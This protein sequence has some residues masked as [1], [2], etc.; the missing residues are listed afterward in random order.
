[1]TQD[2]A[3]AAIPSPWYRSDV[4]A[5]DW[6]AYHAHCAPERVAAVDLASARRFTYATY[7]DRIGRL[8]TYLTKTASVGKGDRI[9][10]LAANSTD[11]LEV[12]FACARIGAIF[13]PINWRLAAPEINYILSDCAPK[14][15][16]FDAEMRALAEEACK[17][18]SIPHELVLDGG[19]AGSSYEVAVTETPF[20][21][22]VSPATQEDAWTILYTSGTTGRP[23]GAIITHA[24]AFWN[25]IHATIQVR[26]SRE[27]VFLAV[28]PLFHTGGL[29]VYTNPC[30]FFGGANIIMR[31][32]DPGE[33]LRII[34]D[35]EIGLTHFFGVPT[36]YQFMM[37][38][39]DFASSDLSRLQI[40]GVG[41]AP[42]ALAVLD[43]WIGRGVTL[44]QGFGMTETGPSVLGVPSH[45][46]KEKVGSAGAPVMNVEI[47]LV[48]DTGRDIE[49]AEEVGELLVRGPSITPG[50][51]G[52]PEAT[53]KSIVDGWLYTGDAAKR[54][55]DG[56]YYIVD[57]VKDMYIS[58]GEN[59]YPAEVEDVIYRMNGVKQAAIVGIPDDR[60]GE[61]GKA[62]LVVDCDAGL[63]EEGVIAHCRENLAK[64]KV[65]VSV[66]FVE[67]LPHNA[68]GK[69]LKRVLRDREIAG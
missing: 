31:T 61:V 13:V 69:I 59:V 45:M 66:A 8:A 21:P 17:G 10:V 23:K 65:P 20:E 58:G 2:R 48:D 26:L 11:V 46:V 25:A 62:F 51:W 1:M 34:S 15:I 24:M 38:H 49:G 54:D 3:D 22:H 64:F 27:S 47:R 5:Y 44:T 63:T 42:I 12:Q 60:W 18:L 36:N 41:G 39:P 50:Y 14:A 33:A 6:I 68:T 43:V 56:Y 40:A 16:V 37:Q 57:R 35:P 52:N 9:A 7:H 30:F 55:A 29:N 67:E 4:P 32:F 28:L 53:Q 19:K